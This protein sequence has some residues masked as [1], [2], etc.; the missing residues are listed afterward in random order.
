MLSGYC[1]R[2][3]H[4]MGEQEKNKSFIHSI[5][6][7]KPKLITDYFSRCPSSSRMNSPIK[8]SVPNRVKFVRH[9]SA[10]LHHRS[11]VKTRDRPDEQM[12]M[13]EFQEQMRAYRME[14]YKF[15][16]SYSRSPI[17]Q[18][19]TVMNDSPTSPFKQSA[20]STPVKR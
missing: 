13:T 9:Q 10:P 1:S 7:S 8:S 20:P 14:L 4:E 2:D 6:T 11:P 19:P 3:E 17:K 12:D 18:R 5:M 16:S 15:K